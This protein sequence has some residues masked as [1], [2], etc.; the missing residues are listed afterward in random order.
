MEEC[1]DEV[2][3]L[4]VINKVYYRVVVIVDFMFGEGYIYIPVYCNQILNVSFDSP[5]KLVAYL[6]DLS[7]SLT[8]GSGNIEIRPIKLNGHIVIN[9]PEKFLEKVEEKE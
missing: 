9:S 4:T 3:R 5:G 1:V 7:T 8:K 2:S 6:S